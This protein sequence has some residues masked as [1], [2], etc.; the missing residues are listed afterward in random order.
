MAATAMYSV[1]YGVVI[2]PF[3]YKDADNLDE[4]V[5]I[6]WRA[7]IFEG[8]AASTISDVLR[9]AGGEPL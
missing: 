2:A 9:V 1:I 7:T 6:A 3:P 4:F 5:E 8:F